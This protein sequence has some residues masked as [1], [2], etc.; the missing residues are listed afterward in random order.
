MPGFENPYKKTVKKA[1]GMAE[2]EAGNTLVQIFRFLGVRMPYTKDV[3]AVERVGALLRR[4]WRT[5]FG[6]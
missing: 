1:P 6:V 5:L 3:R 2:V 4:R